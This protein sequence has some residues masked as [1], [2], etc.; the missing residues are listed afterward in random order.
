MP[1]VIGVGF[2][3]KSTEYFF[4][5]GRFTPSLGEKVVLES[6]FGLEVATVSAK[7]EMR[8]VSSCGKMLRV[9]EEGD[10][11]KILDEIALR[12]AEILQKTAK[13]I[14]EHKLE[15]KLIGID[16]IYD[17]NKIVFFFTADGRV[18]FRGLVRDLASTFKAR[19]ELQQ[20]GVRDEA[21]ILSGVGMCGEQFCCSRFLRD[22]HPVSIKMAKEQ[23]ISLNPTKIS[24]VCGRLMCCLKYEQESYSHLIKITPKP[25]KAVKTPDGFGIV[26]EAFLLRG[27]VKVVLDKSPESPPLEYSIA[28]VMLKSEF[29]KSKDEAVQKAEKVVDEKPVR[30]RAQRSAKSKA[31]KGERPGAEKPDEKKPSDRP[32]PNNRRPRRSAPPKKDK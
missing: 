26:S 24:G 29:L 16:F 13:Q 17:A 9:A 19:I 10:E 4:A 31:E 12:K 18:D 32:K 1:T 3:N 14:A 22:F 30:P 25:G 8:D 27:K 2:N 23:G 6:H 11:A 28:D 21:K 5:C 15:M 20:V 7:A